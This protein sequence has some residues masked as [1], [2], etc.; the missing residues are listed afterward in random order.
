[1]LPNEIGKYVKQWGGKVEKGE[2]TGK[3]YDYEL[4]ARRRGVEGAEWFSMGFATAGEAGAD[5]EQSRLNYPDREFKANRTKGKGLPIWKVEITPQMKE[6]IPAKGQSLF[7]AVAPQVQDDTDVVS[8]PLA[9][10]GY[11]TRFL[12]FITGKKVE[13]TYETQG[14]WSAGGDFNDA[15]QNA[16]RTKVQNGKSYISNAAF[17]T[18]E[19]QRIVKALYPAG[20]TDAQKKTVNLALGNLENRLTQ[21]QS[22]HAKTIRDSKLKAQYL[23]QAERSNIYQQKQQQAAALNSLPAEL[24]DLI[25]QKR[26]LINLMNEALMNEADI[27]A[28]LKEAIEKNKGTYLH[29]SYQIFEDNDIWESKG[30]WMRRTP[31]RSG[32]LTRQRT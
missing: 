20:M 22:R 24:R 10:R 6:T 30:F 1:M 15:I 3:K 17:F 11:L 13:G 23:D 5:L 29:R 25:V 12:S 31:K 7:G 2:I 26:D 9:P 18:N 4:F 32:S 14:Y 16:L 8:S 19:Y 21:A 27:S 28:D